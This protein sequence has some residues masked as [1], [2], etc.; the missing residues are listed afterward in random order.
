MKIRNGFVSNSSSSSFIIQ[1]DETF[2]NT[3][4]IAENM[5][6]N[7]FDE[8]RDYRKDD[9]DYDEHP[10]EQQVYRNI[11]KL[12]NSEHNNMPFFFRSTNY[13][14][15]IKAISDKYAYVDTCNNILWDIKSVAIY[16]VPTELLGIYP[17]NDQYGELDIEIKYGDEY[18]VLESGLIAKTPPEYDTCDK[19]YDPT[20]Y[21]NGVKYCISCDWEKI[22]R[23][24]KINKVKNIIVN[25]K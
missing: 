9:G 2:P 19:C 17:D 16:K 3:L 1:F 7:R 5:I 14:T 18:Y 10:S 23:G 6:R 25:S 11:E 21:I 13:D 20:W 4:A 12:R 24:L 8:W 22:A 15:Y